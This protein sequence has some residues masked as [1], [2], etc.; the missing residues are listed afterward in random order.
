[1]KSEFIY[2]LII[3]ILNNLIVISISD[4]HDH[5]VSTYI[6]STPLITYQFVDH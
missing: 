4:E 3:L 2:L 5:T 1:M 6:L